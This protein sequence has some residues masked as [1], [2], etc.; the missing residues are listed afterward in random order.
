MSLG[1]NI[2]RI[3]KAK[4]WSQRFLA[5]R[6]GTDASYINRI[7]TG[8]I[9]PSVAT[10]EPIADCLECSIDYLVKGKDDP[11]VNISDKNLV[12]RVQLIDTLEEED[13]KALMHMIDTMLTKKRMRD[14]LEGK[15]VL[16]G[17]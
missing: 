15:A 8:K 1:D 7:K 11:E 10:I 13:R 2:R 14:L 17:K 5:E 12:E 3:R 16:M 6:I 9:N 4:G